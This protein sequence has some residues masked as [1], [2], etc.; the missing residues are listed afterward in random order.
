MAYRQTKLG[1]ILASTV[2]GSKITRRLFCLK[3]IN[4]IAGNDPHLFNTVI[5]VFD[6][7][8]KLNYRFKIATITIGLLLQN[9]IPLMVLHYPSGTSIKT[10]VH[11][12]Q[13][14]TKGTY[15]CSRTHFVKLFYFWTLFRYRYFR[16]VR[17]WPRQEHAIL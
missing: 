9:L 5:I 3:I 17:L 16:K 7:F 8:L 11:N 12:L 1:T 14:L 2:C 10:F 6:N 15:I 13:T 4:F